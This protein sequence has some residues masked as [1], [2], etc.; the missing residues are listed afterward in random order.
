MRKSVIIGAVAALTAFTAVTAPAAGK[1]KTKDPV[2][3]TVAG[4]QVPLSEFEYLYK[5]NNSQQLQPQTL[6]E[7]VD[8]FVTYKLKVADAEAAGIDT[9]ASFINEFEGYRDDLAEPYL[10]DTQYEDSLL[11]VAY[12]HSVQSVDVSHIMV[13]LADAKG[14]SDTQIALLDSLR[15]LV[16]NGADLGDLAVKYSIDQ[17]ASIN[18]GHLGNIIGGQ[19]PYEFED[20]AYKTAPGQVSP[21]FQ[22][23]FGHH[24]IKAGERKPNPGEVHVRHILKL[25]RGLSPEQAAE[26]KQQIDSVY[27][28]IKGGADFAEAARM[29]SDD[30]GSARNGGDL[31]WFSLG[32]MV[33]E[34]EKVAFELEDGQISE[35]FQS[36][37][38]WHI[39][40]RLGHRGVP[41]F[42]KV[43][44]DLRKAMDRDI[45]GKWLA[46]RRV[47]RF[48]HL[49]PVKYDK[50]VE[51]EVKDILSVAGLDSVANVRLNA[52]ENNV[53]ATIGD[54]D[55]TV[56]EIVEAIG[57]R[58][59]K[60]SDASTAYDMVLKQ[61]ADEAVLD[62]AR[63][64][65]A[66]TNTDYRNLLG[67]YH[68]GMLLYEISNRKVWDRAS[69]DTDGMQT[70]FEAN[71]GNYT[72]Q[73]PHYKGYIVLAVNDSVLSLAKDFLSNRTFESTDSLNAAL[74]TRF[75]RDAKAEHV[76]TAKGD[77][78]IVD[79]AAFGGPVPPE[80]K[81]RRLNAW[82]AFQG[83]IIDEP[84][85][86]SDVKGAV[87]TDYQQEL[88]R[89]W[90]D[91]LHAKYPVKI[92]KKVLKKI[93]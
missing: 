23:R 80:Q 43:R 46:D 58:S 59:V 13:A 83:R 76:V 77:N 89:R 65:L 56:G 86:A 8:M 14:N 29:H 88:E 75:G 36:A 4:K 71:R 84:E 34:F 72:W 21:V 5:K 25:T 63:D 41:D 39:V 45:R 38:G 87:S 92:N 67:E 78:P 15:S 11:R 3:M 51:A 81:G 48:E 93:K 49:Y 31:P 18:R 73:K 30:Q 62:Q 22:T 90:V 74:K 6:D 33:P 32:R 9:L 70:F 61:L 60:A 27:A 24:F 26:K 50:A 79:F 64:N 82:F 35:P 42:D 69:K 10:V 68:D 40:E 85:E 54:E 55:V 20:M 28:A 19:Y 44:P 52:I 53:A 66:A 7:Y 1:K 37:F 57:E 16:A 17:S 12:D 2:L 47:S 91:G